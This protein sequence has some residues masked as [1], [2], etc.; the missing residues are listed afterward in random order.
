M[1][2]LRTINGFI[3]F[4]LIYWHNDLGLQLKPYR[5]NFS[6]K[7][8]LTPYPRLVH[9]TD[10]HTLPSLAA[11]WTSKVS[12][13]ATKLQNNTLFETKLGKCRIPVRLIVHSMTEYLP[14]PSNST[15]SSHNWV[16]TPNPKTFMSLSDS[17]RY[18]VVIF[19]SD[20]VSTVID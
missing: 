15:V 16:Q 4:L 6:L 7:M 18:V 3:L 13:N 12:K 1:D 19:I 10:S 17:S 14:T 8:K 20:D 9:K 11:L 5:G 2:L